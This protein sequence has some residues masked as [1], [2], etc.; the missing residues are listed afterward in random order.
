[1]NQ[2]KFQKV[3]NK[4]VKKAMADFIKNV[5][6][7][8][9]ERLDGKEIEEEIYNFLADTLETAVSEGRICN[10]LFNKAVFK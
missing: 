7:T 10:V 4:Q 9:Y 1:M 2:T 3:F 6:F 5:H 8:I